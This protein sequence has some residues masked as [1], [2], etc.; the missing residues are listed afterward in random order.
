VTILEG[1]FVY[2]RFPKSFSRCIASAHVEQSTHWC[3]IWTKNLGLNLTQCASHIWSTMS[4]YGGCACSIEVH[5]SR[6]KVLDPIREVF[7]LELE[8]ATKGRV[9]TG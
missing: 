6:S 5:A 8:P 4:A 3:R 7:S 9:I 2:N 1:R